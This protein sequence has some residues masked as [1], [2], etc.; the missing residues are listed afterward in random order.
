[1]VQKVVVRRLTEGL[2]G[3]HGYLGVFCPVRTALVH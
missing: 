1:M 3:D 2:L